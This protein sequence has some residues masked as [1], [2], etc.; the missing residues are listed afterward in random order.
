MN[1]NLTPMWFKA[2]TEFFIR[3]SITKLAGLVNRYAI[4]MFDDSISTCELI[5]M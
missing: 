2:S 5:L 4:K 1:E 3:G